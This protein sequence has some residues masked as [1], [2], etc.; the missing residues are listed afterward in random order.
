[1][2]V[3]KGAADQNQGKSEK[4]L[5]RRR[6]IA[7]P[8]LFM[9]GIAIVL[10]AAIYF[11]NGKRAAGKMFSYYHLAMDT[12]IELE[13]QAASRSEA[14]A[15]K[16]KVFAEITRLERLLSRSIPESDVNRVNE[17]AGSA[18]VRVEPDDHRP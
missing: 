2:T 7:G 8:A 17:A 14:D 9:I 13:L 5:P 1:M 11:I 4:K 10:A 16:A 6:R 18:A 3:N 15:A 12:G